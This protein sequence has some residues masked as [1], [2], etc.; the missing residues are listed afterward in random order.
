V[1]NLAQEFVIKQTNIEQRFDQLL[2]SQGGAGQG[3][4]LSATTQIVP[5]VD[6]TP[7]AENSDFPQS[8]QEAFSHTNLTHNSVTNTTTN[9]ATTPGFYR[10]FAT[11]NSTAGV[12]KIDITDGFSAKTIIDCRGNGG[13][14]VVDFITKIEAGDT[15]RATST[16]A[17]MTIN[18]TTRQVATI[19]GSL[20]NP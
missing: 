18:V 6:L 10:V 3:V 15:L 4:D 17:N 1:A 12:G 16:D 14:N 19:T 2:P 11:F 13:D 8:L 5:I 9:L 20:I 7:S